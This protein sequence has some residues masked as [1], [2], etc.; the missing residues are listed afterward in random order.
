MPPGLPDLGEGGGAARAEQ[1]EHDDF[2]L[3]LEGIDA[4]AGG[5]VV[6][7]VQMIIHRVTS[8]TGKD[9]ERA[10]PLA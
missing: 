2:H 1:A 8:A 4:I 7:L 10:V 6:D 9:R 3:C 5:V